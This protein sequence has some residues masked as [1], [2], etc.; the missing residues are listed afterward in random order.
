MWNKKLEIDIMIEAERERAKKEEIILVEVKDRKQKVNSVEV[1]KFIEIIKNAKEYY[2]EEV[3]GIYISESGFTRGAEEKL[4]EAGIMKSMGLV[5]GDVIKIEEGEV[6]KSKRKEKKR[7]DKSKKKRK[8]VKSKTTK[9]KGAKK[10]KKSNGRYKYEARE[11]IE[12][13]EIKIEGYEIEEVKLG[14]IKISKTQR[15]DIEIKVRAKRRQDKCKKIY[16]KA[17]RGRV[18]IEKAKKYVEK[19]KKLKKERGVKWMYISKGGF[20]RDAEEYLKKHK[21]EIMEVK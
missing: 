21:I 18:Y 8:Q 16:V 19:I 5:E 17:V 3:K 2:K 6:S 10:Q 11:Q 4:R 14:E 13:G 7:E 9:T 1:E 12:K 20:S 15:I